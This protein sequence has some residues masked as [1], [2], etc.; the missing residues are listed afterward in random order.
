MVMKHI[1]MPRISLA[2]TVALLFETREQARWQLDESVIAGVEARELPA[3]YLS[4]SL[5]FIEEF[6]A[7][8]SH[9]AR[10]AARSHTDP[11]RDD[12]L[13][14]SHPRRT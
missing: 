8:M 3:V 6:F 5:H 14:H 1:V 7:R 2:S 10:D 12:P 4:T 9:L 11:M 13:A